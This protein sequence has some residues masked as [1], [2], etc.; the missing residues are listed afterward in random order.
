MRPIRIPISVAA[1]SEVGGNPVVQT[2]VWSQATAA[3]AF[4]KE[5]TG[6][7]VGGPV[8]LYRG[9]LADYCPDWHLGQ[10]N[11]PD[12]VTRLNAALSGRYKI[13]RQLGEGGMATPRPMGSLAG[14]S[15]WERVPMPR[16]ALRDKA[17]TNNGL[18]IRG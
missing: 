1:A 7:S 12:P 14:P 4:L 6:L 15:P 3:P 2:A 17:P 5:P 11:H 10:V 9:F 8:V 13:E 16:T 18:S